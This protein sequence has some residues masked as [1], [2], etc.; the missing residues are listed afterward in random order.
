MKED[1]LF[2]ILALALMLLWFFDINII[3]SISLRAINLTEA[4]R[5]TFCF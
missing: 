5:L 1:F 4:I 2:I 3:G